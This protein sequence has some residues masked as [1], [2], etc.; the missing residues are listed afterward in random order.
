[1]D[2]A[3]RREVVAS[4]CWVLGWSVSYV[5]SNVAFQQRSYY[6]IAIESAS[7]RKTAYLKKIVT[8]VIQPSAWVGRLTGA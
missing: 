6:L 1:M 4:L 5:F 7:K 8:V 2:Y 3:A